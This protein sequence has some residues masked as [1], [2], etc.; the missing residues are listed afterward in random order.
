MMAVPF[1]NAMVRSR[2]P[3]YAARNRF[4]D[5]D[6]CSGAPVWCFQRFGRT[7]TAL[8]DGRYVEIAGEHEDFYD[9]DFCIYNDVV[10]YH[11]DGTFTLY[12]YPAEVFP[13]TDFHTATLVGTSIYLI[14]S[15]GYQGQ[16]R[17]G[18][19]PVRRLDCG[20][21]RIEPVATRGTP[22]GWISRHTAAY[23]RSGTGSSSPA[24]SSSRAPR[25]ASSTSTTPTSMP[26]ISR[27]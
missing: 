26:S 10:V 25:P 13:P 11:G 27:P 1:W 19:T 20:S 14:G 15:L 4:G 17:P 12:G 16:R 18:E 24:A 9:P 8:A 7:L 21:W 23:T 2:E 5:G 22:P 6:H 3:A